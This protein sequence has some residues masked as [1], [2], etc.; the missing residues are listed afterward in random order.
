MRK[1][2]FHDL[3]HSFIS[4]IQLLTNNDKV[5]QK[6]A[7]HADASF[8]KRKYVH[9]KEDACTETLTKY[10]DILSDE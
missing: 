7:R 5:L 1:I 4:N 10:L 3:R 2:R 9:I 8:T 6:I